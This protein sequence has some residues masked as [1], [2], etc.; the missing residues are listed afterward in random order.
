LPRVDVNLILV[1]ILWGAL[2][3]FHHFVR[4]V[5]RKPGRHQVEVIAAVDDLDSA[6]RL[7]VDHG[8][9]AWEK[10]ANAEGDYLFIP[11]LFALCVNC[12]VARG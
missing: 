9:L 10:V 6:H 12:G 5:I 7:K 2:G 4:L 1:G 11:S 3:A 8:R